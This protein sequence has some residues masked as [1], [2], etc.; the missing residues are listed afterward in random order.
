MHNNSTQT[1]SGGITDLT[2]TFFE[3]LKVV[4]Q[5]AADEKGLKSLILNL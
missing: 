2:E 1:A 5:L 3:Q 4:H